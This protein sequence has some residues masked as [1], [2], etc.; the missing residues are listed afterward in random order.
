MVIVVST[1][2]DKI[3]EM[4]VL[5]ISIAVEFLSLNLKVLLTKRMN[6]DITDQKHLHTAVHASSFCVMKPHAS[7]F[8]FGFVLRTRVKSF[9]QNFLE[10]LD[11]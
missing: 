5:I 2:N 1:Y 8:S 7:N 10:H 11:P 9:P 3:G 4:V 6:N